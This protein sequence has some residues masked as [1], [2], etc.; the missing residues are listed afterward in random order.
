MLKNILRQFITQAMPLF[1]IICIVAGMLDYAGITRWLS[2]TTAPLLH[3]FKLPA[4]LMPG[5]IIFTAKER[6]FDG[7][8][9]GWRQLNTVSQHISVTA[10]CLARL[11]VDGLP[12]HGIYHRPGNKLAVCSSSGGKT[13]IKFSGGGSGDIPV[14]YS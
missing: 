3:L 14:I 7:A 1:L 8:Q 6:W 9:S 13:G 10:T 2:E 11:Y 4:E 5:I 12:C